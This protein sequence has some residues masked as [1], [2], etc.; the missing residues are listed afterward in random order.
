[1]NK[2]LNSYGADK[3]QATLTFTDSVARLVISY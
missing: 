1:M 2:S 3:K